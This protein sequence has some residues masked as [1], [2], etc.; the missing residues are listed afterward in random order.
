MRKYL[1]TVVQVLNLK[2]H[3]LDMLANHLGHDLTVVRKYYRLQDCT[4]EQGKI[5]RFLMSTD[6]DIRGITPRKSYP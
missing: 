5:E 6:G 1:A 3:E 4:I 2:E